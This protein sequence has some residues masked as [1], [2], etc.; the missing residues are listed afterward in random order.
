[1]EM[2][3][4][5]GCDV[6]VDARKGKE[7]VVKQVRAAT[8]GQGVDSAVC[9]SDHKDAAGVSC[10]ITKMHGTMVQIAQPDIVEIPFPEIIFRDIRIVGSLISSADESVSMLE[11]IA[12]HGIT[13]STHPFE[14]LEQIGELVELVHGGKLKGKAIIV[15]D[16]EQIEYEKTIGAKY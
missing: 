15:V 14:G 8:G 3:E 13:V 1:L 12:K 7:E 9:L 5:Y 4:K 10:A 16:P 11:T 2:S 6:V